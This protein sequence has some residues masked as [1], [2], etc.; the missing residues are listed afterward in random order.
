MSTVGTSTMFFLA[1][2]T[3]LRIASGTSCALPVPKPT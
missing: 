3:A 1:S 2:S